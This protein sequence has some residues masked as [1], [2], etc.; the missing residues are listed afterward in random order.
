MILP[1][2]TRGPVRGFRSLRSG[3]PGVD[4]V[5]GREPH[6]EWSVGRKS[7]GADADEG[8]LLGRPRD[9]AQHYPVV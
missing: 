8:R 7:A 6:V 1:G 5:L 4:Q 2:W 9:L 3:P